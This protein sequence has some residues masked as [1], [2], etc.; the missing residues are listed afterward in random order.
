MTTTVAEPAVPVALPRL[1]RADVARENRTSRCRAPLPLPNN[2]SF[3]LHLQEA[4]AELPPPGEQLR[5]R[6]SVGEDRFE[7]D[8][9][10]PLML[11]L[12]HSLEG[13]LRL[14][15]LPPPETA[16]LLLESALLPLVDALERRAGRTVLLD[17][18]S[19]SDGTMIPGGRAVLLRGTGLHQLLVLGGT[20]EGRARLLDGWPDG[21]RPLGGLP[22]PVALV[23]GSTVLTTRLLRS[24]RVG[25]AV[26][27]Q[28]IETG[29]AFDGTAS[30]TGL[31]V[32]DS[33][34]APV[35]NTGNGWRLLAPLRR[36]GWAGQ[37]VSENASS[38]EQHR[39]GTDVAGTADPATGMA[40]EV[41]LDELPIRLVFE[42]G[43]LE[44]S[45]GALRGLGVGSVLE[46][47]GEPGRVA[48]LSGSR[49]I[50]SGSLVSVEGRAGIRIESFADGLDTGFGA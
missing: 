49:R 12:I 43:R 37:V 41:D 34:G 45:L 16:A 18:L 23:H 46:F 36:I 40:A 2:E 29:F 9:P 3:S 39:S 7:A 42:A 27:L 31:R 1:S 14:D 28:H 24:L 50:G 21:R 25:D 8:L 32:A 19:G 35:R 20:P 10:R 15:P 17:A 44:L 4:G 30:A 11:D 5:L 33:L 47:D 13:R 6:F 38:A 48:I 26:L 22:V